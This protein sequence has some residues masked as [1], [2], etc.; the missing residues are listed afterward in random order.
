MLEPGFKHNV[1][2]TAEALFNRVYFR[3]QLRRWWGWLTGRRCELLFLGDIAHESLSVTK[4]EKTVGI[5]QIRGTAGRSDR[6]DCRFRPKQRRDRE[7]WKSIAV[8]MMTDPLM[9]RIELVQ[10]DEVYYVVDGHHRVS[11]A[12]ALGKISIDAVVVIWNFE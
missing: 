3:G 6:F 10:V 4:V 11:V 2:Q 12:R 7:R 8:G 9:P 5:S 1:Y